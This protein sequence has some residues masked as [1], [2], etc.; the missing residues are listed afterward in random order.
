MKKFLYMMRWLLLQRRYRY[1]TAWCACKNKKMVWIKNIDPY[2]LKTMITLKNKRW[3]GFGI[4][5]RWR[6]R[7]RPSSAT[8]PSRW[9]KEVSPAGASQVSC[10]CAA[11][12][13][14]C[15]SAACRVVP[16]CHQPPL[17][18]SPVVLP[19]SP[20]AASFYRCPR[21]ALLN[22]GI[23]KTQQVHN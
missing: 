18:L 21:P 19:R 7:K 11:H 4:L 12:P 9:D 15:L 5:W 17:W 20:H 1:M 16:P 2:E 23:A 6:P 8:D 14:P 13:S 3:L 22:I 10:Q